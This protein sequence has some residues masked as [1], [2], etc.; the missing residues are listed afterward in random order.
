M[1]FIEIG[2]IIF[3]TRRT[4]NFIDNDYCCIFKFTLVDMSYFFKV[5]GFL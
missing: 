2:F 4:K 5:K 1:E 3:N